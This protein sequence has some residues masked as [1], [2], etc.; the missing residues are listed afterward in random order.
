MT[1]HLNVYNTLVIQITYVGIK[2]K[3]RKNA[4]HFM[5][6]FI[7]ESCL[8]NHVGF[9]L[10]MVVVAMIASAGTTEHHGPLY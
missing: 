3:K 2:W 6:F 9:P 4:L 8:F 7:W 1:S 5:I 10:A